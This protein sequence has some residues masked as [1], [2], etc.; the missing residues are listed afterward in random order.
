MS[1]IVK[2]IAKVF[3][4]EPYKSKVDQSDKRWIDASINDLFEKILEYFRSME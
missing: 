1:D 4:N 3:Q 2:R